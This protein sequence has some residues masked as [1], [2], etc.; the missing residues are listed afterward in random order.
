[1]KHKKC[2]GVNILG[3]AS[4]V[5]KIFEFED[6]KNFLGHQFC[7]DLIIMTLNYIMTRS[8]MLK[9]LGFILGPALPLFIDKVR[10]LTEVRK[11]VVGVGA[12]GYVC[13]SDIKYTL[14]VMRVNKLLKLQSD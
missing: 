1:M 14:D 11:L 13:V 8:L 7:Q 12:P 9:Y 2:D 4:W 5:I 3:Q 10:F 6:L